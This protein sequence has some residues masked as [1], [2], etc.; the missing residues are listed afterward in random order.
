MLQRHPTSLKL[1]YRVIRTGKAKC[2]QIGLSTLKTIAISRNYIGDGQNL[3]EEER[4][5]ISTQLNEVV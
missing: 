5:A 4:L 1:T 2:F 3:I